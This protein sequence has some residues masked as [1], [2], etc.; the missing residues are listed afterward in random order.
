M[1]TVEHQDQMIGIQQ[2]SIQQSYL[3]AEK[4]IRRLRHMLPA[5]T[6]QATVADAFPAPRRFLAAIE[7]FYDLAAN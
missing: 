3:I 1:Q 2:F 5:G 7:S 4:S 6:P